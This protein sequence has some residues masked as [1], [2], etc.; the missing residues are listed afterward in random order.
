MSNLL[1]R[2]SHQDKLTW[3]HFTGKSNI[4]IIIKTITNKMIAVYSL[5]PLFKPNNSNVYNGKESAFIYESD[6][7]GNH[8]DYYYMLQDKKA[9]GCY[10]NTIAFGKSDLRFTIG[11]DTL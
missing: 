10:G 11:D 9:N 7:V 3:N 6:L 5:A 1:Y 4:L 8:Q 2:Y